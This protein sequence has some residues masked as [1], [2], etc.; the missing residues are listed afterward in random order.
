MPAAFR[1]SFDN[2]PPPSDPFANCETTCHHDLAEGARVKED[3]LKED[4]PHEIQ[5]GI[6]KAWTWAGQPTD[7]S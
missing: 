1:S 6:P 2:E 4:G 5:T 7:R 3:L